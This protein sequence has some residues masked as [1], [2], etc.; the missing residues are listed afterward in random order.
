[1]TFK[2]ALADAGTR[3]F[4]LE[5]VEDPAFESEVLLRYAMRIS[6]A[7]LFLDL[8]R[9]L[10]P[11]QANLFQEWVKR[12]SLGEPTAYIIGSREFFGLDFYVD[13]RVLIPRPE[14]ELLVEEAIRFSKNYLKS[15]S[16]SSK[17]KIADI[18]TGS[19][20]VAVSLA[21]NLSQAKIYATDISV[22]ALKVA[23]INIRKY[24]V[25][26]QVKL[27]QGNLLEPLPEKVDLLIA[28]LPYVTR[29]DV[30]RMPSAR[31]EP[32]LALDGGENGLDKIFQLCRQ[33]KGKLR[34]GG[35]L[36]L[37]IGLGQD[38]AVTNLLQDLFSSSE[39]ES[40]KDLAGIKRAIR[41]VLSPKE[42]IS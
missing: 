34:Q 16:F 23:D 1:V 42:S 19:G 39:V 8:D 38:Q 17:V 15:F 13:T 2:Q 24:Q 12:R 36:L 35:C 41:L 11:E 22:P 25:T 31:Y 26:E 9:E 21:V 40:L 33:I 7:K 30:S 10:D 6:R 27:L 4:G 29:S 32:I 37:E 20:A 3:L 5:D 18:G 28:N 14:T